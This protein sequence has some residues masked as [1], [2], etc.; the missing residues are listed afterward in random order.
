MILGLRLHL[1]LNKISLD[2]KLYVHL[3]WNL[4]YTWFGKKVI[5]W[6]KNKSCVPTEKNRVNRVRRIK[7]T[8]D[9]REQPFTWSNVYPL[10]WFLIILSLDL[11]LYVHLIWNV[12]Y[13]WFRKK[14]IEWRKKKSCVPTQKNRVNRVR[15][16]KCT[17]DC[18]T[19][20]IPCT[21]HLISVHLIS[22]T[23]D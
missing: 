20:D 21:V 6:R 7:C 11:K 3:I 19:L 16:I 1:I 8:L 22:C 17:L 15:R 9:F 13:T 23:L 5:E 14:V 10:I 18:S 4:L 12:P 2:L